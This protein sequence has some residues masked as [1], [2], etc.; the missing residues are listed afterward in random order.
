M[1]IE[2]RRFEAPLDAPTFF[3]AGIEA[4]GEY[5]CAGCGYGIS[6]RSLLPVC[7]M[8]RGDVWEEPGGSPYG[9][10]VL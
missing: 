2:S 7:P 1:Q 4:R 10:A 9:H 5:R 6:V 8:C 3:S